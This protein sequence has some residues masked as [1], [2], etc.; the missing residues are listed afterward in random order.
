MVTRYFCMQFNEWKYHIAGLFE[1]KLTNDD[2]MKP[3]IFELVIKKASQKYA[4]IGH[5]TSLYIQNGRLYNK[6]IECSAHFSI[7][8]GKSIIFSICYC[9]LSLNVTRL[10]NNIEILH[11]M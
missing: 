5:V 4:N 7:C 6:I 11:H 10:C 1:A 8:M 9:I 3:Y 2:L